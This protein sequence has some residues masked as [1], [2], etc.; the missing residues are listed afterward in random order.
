[1]KEIDIFID[2]FG[3]VWYSLYTMVENRYYLNEVLLILGISKNTYYNWE[4]SQKIPSAKRDPMNNY[5]YWTQDDL[6][7]LKKITGRK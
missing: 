4:K 6:N 1:M 3:Y 7:E 2:L 5:R